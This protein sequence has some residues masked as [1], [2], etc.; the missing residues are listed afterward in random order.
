[1]QAQ[2]CLPEVE[3]GTCQAILCC[4][5]WQK[6]RPEMA[7]CRCTQ[8]PGMSTLPP[9]PATTISANAAT[10]HLT[11]PPLDVLPEGVLAHLHPLLILGTVCVAPHGR[12]LKGARS[13]ACRH[14]GLHRCVKMHIALGP[15]CAWPIVCM[16]TGLLR[17]L[18]YGCAFRMPHGVQGANR[19]SSL[20]RS[21]SVL[22]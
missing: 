22:P 20:M 17:C 6:P 1:M 19:P 15:T 8:H 14:G 9:K 13:F 2:P 11:D 18:G 16:A 10:L 4:Q 5:H 12:Q 7:A 3:P 21:T